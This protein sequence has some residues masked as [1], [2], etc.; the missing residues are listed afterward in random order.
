[1]ES[2]LV[3]E[4]NDDIRE[5]VVELLRPSGLDVIEA[6]NGLVGLSKLAGMAVLPCVVLLDLA[7]PVMGGLEMLRILQSTGRLGA[8]SVVVLSA[9]GDPLLPPG[10]ARFMRKPL[11]PDAL[12]QV[13]SEL[14]GVVCCG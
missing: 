7:M 4:D 6:E 11:S 12:L 9:G 13:V 2:I 8:M 5:M 1:M 10:V 14:S 3:V